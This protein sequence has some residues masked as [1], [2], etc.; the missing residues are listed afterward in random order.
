M[1]NFAAVPVLN[2]TLRNNLLEVLPIKRYLRRKRCCLFLLDDEKNSDDVA[3]ELRAKVLRRRWLDDV[4]HLVRGELSPAAAVALQR[5]RAAL[6]RCGVR[7]T[8][9]A[10][11]LC[12]GANLGLPGGKPWCPGG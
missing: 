6:R 5:S 8:Q 12:R 3:Q 11:S 10:T 7:R 9:P 2:I 4:I 1:L